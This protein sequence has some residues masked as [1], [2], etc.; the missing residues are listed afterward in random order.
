MA[1]S[2]DEPPIDEADAE[3]LMTLRGELEQATERARLAGA[4][5]CDA[6]ICLGF[7]AGELAARLP[8]APPL[9]AVLVS[10]GNAAHSG[11]RVAVAKAARRQSF[12]SNGET[13]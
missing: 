10:V 2:P 9:S 5:L 11:H 8:G 3:R 1:M 4:D 7:L 13:K 6:I 12:T